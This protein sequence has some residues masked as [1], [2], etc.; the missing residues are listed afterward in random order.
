MPKWPSVDSLQED[1]K[2]N[3]SDEAGL[4]TDALLGMPQMV[5]KMKLWRP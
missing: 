3:L 1:E 2:H 5:P 4:H